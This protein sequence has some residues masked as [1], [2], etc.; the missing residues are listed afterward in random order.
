MKNSVVEIEAVCTWVIWNVV[1]PVREVPLFLDD[2]L[3]DLAILGGGDSNE[4]GS[5]HGEER[6]EMEV[7]LDW[8]TSDGIGWE[9]SLELG[10]STLQHRGKGR[11]IAVYS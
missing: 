7:M 4:V 10:Q 9:C 5:S 8:D 1:K 11:S 6:L 2:L 3:G